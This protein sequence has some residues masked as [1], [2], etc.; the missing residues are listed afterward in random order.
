MPQASS[1]AD[2]IDS[3]Y[4]DEIKLLY[5]N[6]LGGLSADGGQS[7]PG[8]EQ[9]C[10]QRFKAGL[11]LARR[12]RELALSAVGTARPTRAAA[13]MESVSPPASEAVS[14]RGHKSRSSAGARPISA[15]PSG[16][17]QIRRR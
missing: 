17:P 3:A 15:A 12:A 16:K 6:L 2:L 1:E 4:E 10:L 8:D 5:K 7:S 14:R 13:S 11:T 9:Q